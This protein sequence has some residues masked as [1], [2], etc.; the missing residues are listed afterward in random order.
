LAAVNSNIFF[1]TV[2]MSLLNSYLCP[3]DEFSQEDR[4]KIINYAMNPLKTI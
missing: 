4:R 1:L 2:L 3:Y